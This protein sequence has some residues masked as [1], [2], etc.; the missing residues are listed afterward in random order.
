MI[1]H[2]EMGLY[3][4]VYAPSRAGSVEMLK[5]PFGTSAEAYHIL[6][7]MNLVER[8]GTYVENTRMKVVRVSV[9]I[10][11]DEVKGVASVPNA[12]NALGDL[13]RAKMYG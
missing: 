10:V 5:G 7:T 12:E 9:G 3:Y 4:V 8:A 11:F 6:G 1:K 13:L 2:T